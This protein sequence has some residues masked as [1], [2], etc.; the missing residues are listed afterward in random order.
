[1]AGADWEALLERPLHEFRRTL[2]IVPTGSYAA[3]K[4]EAAR[5]PRL[6]HSPKAF[7]AGWVGLAGVL[8]S[9]L[10]MVAVAVVV[11]VSLLLRFAADGVSA[12]RKTQLVF[13]VLI[14]FSL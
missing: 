9:A 3:L 8:G 7:R 4:S 11:D 6:T 10:P 2:G 14:L 13:P 1:M 12:A 5:R